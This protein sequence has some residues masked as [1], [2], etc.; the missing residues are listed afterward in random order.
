MYKYVVAFCYI[1][2]NSLNIIIGSVIC[3]GLGA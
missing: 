2:N 1:N 3:E